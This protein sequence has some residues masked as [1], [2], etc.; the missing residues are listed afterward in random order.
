MAQ[1]Y[2]AEEIFDLFFDKYNDGDLEKTK[3]IA[4]Q[5]TQQYLK[6]HPE[7]DKSEW[8]DFVDNIELNESYKL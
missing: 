3:E 5:K 2:T 4:S 1:K 8:N 6:S 7:I